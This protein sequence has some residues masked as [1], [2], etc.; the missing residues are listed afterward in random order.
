MQNAVEP[1]ESMISN[2]FDLY[3]FN[4]S[5]ELEWENY[6]QYFYLSPYFKLFNGKG[7][8]YANNGGGTND[9][10]TVEINGQLQP[11]NEE[12]SFPLVYDASADFAGWNLVGNPYAHNVTAYTATSVENGCF[13]INENHDDLMV[14]EVSATDPLQPMEGFFVKA[15][16]TDANISFNTS[17]RDATNWRG[18]SIYV[19]VLQ[20]GMTIDRLIV[21]DNEQ[22]PLEKFSLN[23]YRTKVFAMR[24]HREMSIV[25]RE[26]NEQAISFKAEKD[27]TYAL[28]VNVEGVDL[29]YLHLVDNLTG[30]DVVVHYDPW[31]N[32]AAQNQA[33]DRAHRIGQEKNVT[34]YK[35]IA[36]NTIEEKI[37]Q[38]QKKKSSLADSVLTGEVVNLSSLSKDELMDILN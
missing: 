13:R 35:L 24:D 25:S 29:D 32:V 33:T 36:K 8:L 4:Q 17:R 20:D 26:G 16:G 34:V 9:A 21:K 18:G 30:A 14:S 1:M 28:K 27:G 2:A 19:D 11:G 3:R 22:S 37:Q 7:Y 10:V 12:L 5:N 38:L 31:W 15:T 6:L 23:Q